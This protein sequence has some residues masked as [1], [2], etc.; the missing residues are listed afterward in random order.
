MDFENVNGVMKIEFNFEFEFF[1]C[2]DFQVR[3]T[4]LKCFIFEISFIADH[5]LTL[6][7]FDN[8]L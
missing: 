8:K 2:F 1:Y 7:L 4:H 3:K 6:C 5:S